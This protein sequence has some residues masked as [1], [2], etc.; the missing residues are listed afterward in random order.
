MPNGWWS[1]SKPKTRRRARKIVE[2]TVSF[3]KSWDGKWCIQCWDEDSDTRQIT[4]K[5]RVALPPEVLDA[6]IVQEEGS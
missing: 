2:F 5:L 4:Y 1:M 3:Q 6:E